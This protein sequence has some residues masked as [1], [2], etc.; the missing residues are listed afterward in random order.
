M[1]DRCENPRAKYYRHYGGRG[2]RICDRWRHDFPAFLADMGPRPTEKHTLERIDNARGYSPDNCRWATRWEQAQNRR[3]IKGD[4][5]GH[6][7][8]TEDTIR[9]IRGA[10]GTQREIAQRF[11][12]SQGHV[13]DIRH[14]RRWGHVQP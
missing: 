2:I 11:G 6:A 3:S 9:A 8:L 13:S 1:I 5:H 12:I 10:D 14:R 7:K 4:R